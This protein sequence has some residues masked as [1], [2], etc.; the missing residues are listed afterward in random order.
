MV[1]GDKVAVWRQILPSSYAWEARDLVLCTFLEWTDKDQVWS[2]VL[3]PN[4]KIT[5]V[6]R[7]NLGAEYRKG[8]RMDADKMTE[9]ELRVAIMTLENKGIQ[10]ELTAQEARRLMEL[11]EARDTIR[12]ATGR[13]EPRMSVIGGERYA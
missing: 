10:G 1:R 9:N 13:G 8:C 2:K 3:T 11:R 7:D 12:R 6:H 4:D 5:L